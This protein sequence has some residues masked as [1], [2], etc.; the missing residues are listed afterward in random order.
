MEEE[1]IGDLY[2]NWWVYKQ[3][4]FGGNI[5]W[6]EILKERMD[7]DEFLWESLMK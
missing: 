3:T 2:Q 5:S 7:N 4:E 1:W 6:V